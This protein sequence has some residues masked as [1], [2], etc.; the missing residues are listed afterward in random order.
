MAATQI[1]TTPIFG[2]FATLPIAATSLDVAFVAGDPVNG[3]FFIWDSPYGDI[4]IAWNTDSSP[5]HITITSQPDACAGRTGD[6]TN[7]VIGAGVFSVYDFPGPS[8]TGW[9]NTFGHIL[10]STD[11]ALGKFLILER[12]VA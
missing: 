6:I 12:E 1:A 4:L 10:F 3:N 5:H 7:Y 2:P 11:S 8:A 9:A